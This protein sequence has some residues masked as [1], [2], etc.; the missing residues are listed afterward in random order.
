[1]KR[2]WTS[3]FIFSREISKHALGDD[4][5]AKLTDERFESVPQSADDFQA[6]L[7]EIGGREGLSPEAKEYLGSLAQCQFITRQAT[8]YFNQKGA[9]FDRG[10]GASRIP[11][12]S[13]LVAPDMWAEYKKSLGYYMTL[14]TKEYINQMKDHTQALLYGSGVHMK[15]NTGIHNA[16]GI[17]AVPE[18]ATPHAKIGSFVAGGPESGYSHPAIHAFHLASHGPEMGRRV[19]GGLAGGFEAEKS[20]M[21]GAAV[22][23]LVHGASDIFAVAGITPPKVVTQTSILG[24]GWGATKVV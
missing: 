17:L 4:T 21:R 13:E 2:G 11:F 20:P 19:L 9:Y 5:K 7:L 1:M 12:L 6:Y 3:W 23:D 14:H 10:S 18:I 24:S 22:P 16:W 15:T 8:R